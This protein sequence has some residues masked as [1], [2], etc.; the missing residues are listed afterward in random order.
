V[1]SFGGTGL[2]IAVLAVIH[3]LFLVAALAAFVIWRRTVMAE[4][5]GRR[6]RE[7][8]ADG[9]GGSGGE[10][11]GGGRP[12]ARPSA[13]GGS[14]RS[15]SA[16]L[17]TFLF[18]PSPA[19]PKTPLVRQDKAGARA[20][21]G[22]GSGAPSE[23]APGTLHLQQEGRSTNAAGIPPPLTLRPHPGRL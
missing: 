15:S 14:T 13:G 11:E 23:A 19:G 12:G 10:G 21:G 4:E 6:E 20:Q 7:R 18:Q 22:G 2:I 9:G 17:P 5:R 16:S 8:A 1:S 3:L